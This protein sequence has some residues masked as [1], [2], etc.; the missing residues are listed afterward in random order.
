MSK[1]LPSLTPKKLIKVLGKIGFT[2]YKQRGSHK[3]YVKGELQVI[4]PFHN[5]DL[6]KG[7]LYNIVKGTGLTVEEFKKYI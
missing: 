6:K 3:I 5:K 1:D 7:T 2:F 4:V